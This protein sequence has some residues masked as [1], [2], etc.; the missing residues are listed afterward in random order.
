MTDPVDQ[1][2]VESRPAG[3]PAGS[4]RAQRPEAQPAGPKRVPRRRARWAMANPRAVILVWAILTLVLGTA[5]LFAKSVLHPEDLLIRGTPSAE[6]IERD[7]AAFGLTSPVTILLEGPEKQLDRVGPQVVRELNKLQSVSVASPWSAGAPR[8]LRERPDRALL[9]VSINKDVIDAGR[10]V[11]PK[12]QDK[13]DALLPPSIESFVAGESR[14]STE[15]RDLVFSGAQKAEIIAMPFLLLILLL[16]F[17]A[18]I[19]ASVPLIQ[20][21]AVI[22]VTTGF[23]TLLGRIFPVNVLAQASGSI[24]GLALGVDYSLLFVSR[25]R[26]ELASGK[27][28][29]EAVETA[30]ATA[31]R[32]VAFAGGIL[33]LSGLF[34][35]AVTFGWA[36]MT[37]GS[38]GVIAAALF[39][40]AAAYTLLPA[41]LSVL[42]ENINRWPIGKVSTTSAL[43]PWAMRLLKRPVLAS[44]IVLVPLL[45]L[46]A[47]ALQLQTG[48]PDLKMFKPDNPMRTDVE[49]VADNYGGG[50]MS[51]LRGARRR[52]DRPG[53]LPGAR[54]ARSNSFRAS[55][56][57]TRRCDTSSAWAPRRSAA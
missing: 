2:L 25:F 23:V 45:L 44:T 20:G 18:P 57:A 3:V 12:V 52:A 8:M 5:G 33:A 51:P 41:A 32:T 28:V 54:S 36:S 48:G 56:P 30:V 35:I 49:A 39:S 29:D 26:E 47:A 16:I 14:F 50:V 6:A 43:A 1:P 27:S 40:V 13:L 55:S 42:G 53:H 19:A 10:D 11:L 22:I 46:C 24:I 4:P 9:V 37:T 15:L 31:G 21:V 17:R 38:I 34:V 7:T